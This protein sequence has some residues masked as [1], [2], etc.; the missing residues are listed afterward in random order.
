MFKENI[1]KLL[2]G[3]QRNYYN[4]NNTNSNE[5]YSV[6]LSLLITIILSFCSMTI[7][8]FLFFS[9]VYFCNNYKKICSKICKNSPFKRSKRMNGIEIELGTL[10]HKIIQDS[11]SVK[12]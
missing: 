2:M 8:S 1:I 7:I 10:S 3:H 4:Y 6:N 9:L 12:S 11:D 5:D